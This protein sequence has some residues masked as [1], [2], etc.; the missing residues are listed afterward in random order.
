MSWSKRRRRL[1]SVGSAA[2]SSPRE[3]GGLA[4]AASRDRFDALVA[5]VASAAATAG[6]PGLLL[7]ASAAVGKLLFQ[8]QPPAPALPPRSEAPPAGSHQDLDA[9][10]SCS[11]NWTRLTVRSG[12]DCPFIEKLR[13]ASS[14][15]VDNNPL[16]W[17]P[18]GR[19]AERCERCGWQKQQN[20]NVLALLASLLPPFLESFSNCS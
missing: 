17:N 12:H 8:P 15:W 10:S 18:I 11:A 6:P 7:P 4:A 19:A 1:P 9:A 14:S 3:A 16:V 20:P 5:A 2:S 13:A